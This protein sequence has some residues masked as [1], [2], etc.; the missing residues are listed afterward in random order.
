MT[1]AQSLR[2]TADTGAPYLNLLVPGLGQL[3]QRRTGTAL[4]FMVESAL[5]TV[6]FFAV[7][8]LRVPVWLAMLAIMAGSVV[9]TV[10]AGRLAAGEIQRMASAGHDVS[11]AQPQ[12]PHAS[13]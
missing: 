8:G 3:Y 7:P 13:L 11:G 2:R 12:V 5:L 4:H 9:D 1:S 6:L 10:R